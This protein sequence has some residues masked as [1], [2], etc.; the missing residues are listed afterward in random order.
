MFRE[1][2]THSTCTAP[3]TGTS[4]PASRRLLHE[5]VWQDASLEGDRHPTVAA[6]ED[7]SGS[8]SLQGPTGRHRAWVKKPTA[9]HVRRE[10]NEWCPLFFCVPT[11]AAP[12]QTRKRALRPFTGWARF[13]ISA[14]A[15]R[16]PRPD[17]ARRVLKDRLAILFQP[18]ARERVQPH[19]PRVKL[20]RNRSPP[21]P[22][23]PQRPIRPVPPVRV[24]PADQPQLPI[25]RVHPA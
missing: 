7:V 2:W 10:E 21:P 23:T 8:N 24:P 16:R 14:F 9:T 17:V 25:P 18:L 19:P 11:P 15:P 13:F 1:S 5:T 4:T 12:R 3:R 6:V 20:G 22:R